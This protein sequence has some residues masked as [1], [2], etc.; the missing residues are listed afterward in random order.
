MIKYY[1]RYIVE[2]M[3]KNFKDYEYKIYVIIDKIIDYK[4]IFR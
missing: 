2:I 3:G 4:I 1:E